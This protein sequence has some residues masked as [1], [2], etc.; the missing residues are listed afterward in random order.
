MV[1]P[2][3][4]Q[5]VD[6]E[7]GCLLNHSFSSAT[8]LKTSSGTDSS[9]DA[10]V[11]LMSIKTSLRYLD[12]YFTFQSV[13][14]CTSSDIF[15]ER[16]WNIFAVTSVSDLNNSYG[17]LSCLSASPPYSS[18]DLVDFFDCWCGITNKVCVLVRSAVSSVGWA[19]LSVIQNVLRI[20]P[21]AHESQWLVFPLFLT[22]RSSLLKFPT[23]SLV[24]S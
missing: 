5:N 10:S 20:R 2:Y 15:L 11:V 16:R 13:G 12:D 3:E 18:H 7:V 1:D 23:N 14:T 17:T 21:A 9:V 6:L 8:L 22:G 4:S 24:A 19:Y